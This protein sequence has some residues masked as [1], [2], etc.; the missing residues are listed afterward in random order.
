MNMQHPQRNLSIVSFIV[1]SSLFLISGCASNNDYGYY[2]V[3]DKAFVAA[4]DGVKQ[5]AEQ[6]PPASC[7]DETCSMTVFM[8]TRRALAMLNNNADV[9]IT[10]LG[11][12]TL[13]TIP[14]G[15]LFIPA[16]AELTSDGR[17]LLDRIGYIADR[18]ARRIT[19]IGHRADIG[20]QD[21][22]FKITS[23]QANAVAHYLQRVGELHNTPMTTLAL[24]SDQP[25][26][27]ELSTRGRAQ[28]NVIIIHLSDAKHPRPFNY[29]K[30]FVIAPYQF[31][32]S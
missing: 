9:N 21:A 6:A 3:N 11:M 26:A 22:K 13:I 14:L 31:Q 30:R 4:D 25:L 24:G 23:Y 28:N 27:S 15:E 10:T 19:I 1:I 20:S 32:P 7:D 12:D 2:A 5:P 29:Y 8:Q 18:R 17:R 16:T